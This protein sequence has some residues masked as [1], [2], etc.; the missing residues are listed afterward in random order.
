MRR[1]ACLFVLAIAAGTASL[2]ARQA[3]PPGP[4]FV[5][6]GRAAVGELSAKTF[7]KFI[8]RLD[9]KV[10]AALTEPK[11]AAL[12]TQITT[13]SGEFKSVL[14]ARVEMAQG[15]HVVTVNCA[16]EKQNL[17]LRVAF[18]DDQKIVGFFIVPPDP[19]PTARRAQEPVAPLPYREEEVGYSA[20]V[21]VQLAGTLT[22]P[23]G[24]GPFPGVLLVTGSGPQDRN[25]SIA[26]HRPFLVLADYLTRR[27]IAV[28]RVDDRGVGR[29]T[30]SL[31]GRSARRQAESFSHKPAA[32]G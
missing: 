13:Q 21:S 8:A 32:R 23:A 15:A 27:G 11:L 22:I 30:G 1:A 18:N 3:P 12:W 17:G 6:L 16:F 26:G 9:P 20:S 4:D 2:A 7:D 31:A 24:K 28:L 10:G 29:S 25:E 19:L 5:A 14:N